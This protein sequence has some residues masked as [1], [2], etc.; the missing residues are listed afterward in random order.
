MSNFHI[1]K[2]GTARRCQA[3][4]PDACRATKNDMN[5]HFET[6]EEAQ[7]A[8][9]EKMK[10]KGT[11]AK[12]LTRKEKI[13][14]GN[15]RAEELLKAS[16]ELLKDLKN[17]E[18]FE[19]SLKETE[20]NVDEAEKK[21]T[22]AQS[23]AYNIERYKEWL[24]NERE[25][26]KKKQ[27]ESERLI[28]LA[29]GMKKVLDEKMEEN[30]DKATLEVMSEYNDVVEEVI[31]GNE[32]TYLNNPHNFDTYENNLAHHKEYLHKEYDLIADEIKNVEK[33]GRIKKAF[34]KKF[35]NEQENYVKEL[36]ERL[37]NLE[38]RI[39]ATSSKQRKLQKRDADRRYNN[40]VS[41]GFKEARRYSGWNMSLHPQGPMIEY[42]CPECDSYS[43]SRS[44][45]MSISKDIGLIT[46]C[47]NCER[48]IIIPVG[49]S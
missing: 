33:S 28:N 29:K 42:Q 10:E 21:M 38:G 13:A 3:A 41:N 1:S 31:K 46:R 25:Q 15:K 34:N 8:Y 49:R 7:E 44:G 36:D 47:R 19:E 43:K 2:D 32:T 39:N 4:T 48:K 20:K 11:I 6:K 14:A 16:E 45:L 22:P 35:K 30:D 12:S 24:K 9:E 18:Q 17:T 27:E 37:L 26:E 23:K 40:L 5:E